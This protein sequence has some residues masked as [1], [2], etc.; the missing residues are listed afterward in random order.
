MIAPIILA[1]MAALV[2]TM[3]VV[4]NANVWSVSKGKIAKWM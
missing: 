1:K 3:S 2:K 4:T